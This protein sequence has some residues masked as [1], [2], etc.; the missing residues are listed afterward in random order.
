[1]GTM[2]TTRLFAFP[3]ATLTAL[4]LLAQTPSPALLGAATPAALAVPGPEKTPCSKRSPTTGAG[5]C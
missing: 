4:P 2:K 3:L 1:M 5:C